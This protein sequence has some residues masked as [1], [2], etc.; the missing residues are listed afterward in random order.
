MVVIDSREETK[1][2]IPD[3]VKDCYDIKINEQD[4]IITAIFLIQI[5]DIKPSKRI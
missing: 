1:N 4:G 2:K 3:L 5:S